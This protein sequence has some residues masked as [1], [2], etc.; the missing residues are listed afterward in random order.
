MLNKH[1]ILFNVQIVQSLSFHI[2]ERCDEVVV[3]A[4]VKINQARKQ[5]PPD[6]ETVVYGQIK[7]AVNPD[8]AGSP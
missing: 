2:S 6:T 3:Y 1:D 7:M 8:V 5:R 4:D